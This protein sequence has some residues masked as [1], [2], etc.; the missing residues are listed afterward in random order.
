FFLLGLFG[1]WGWPVRGVLGTV[2][3][4][5]LRVNLRELYGGKDKTV[6]FKKYV[7]CDA[8]GGTGS[9]NGG[10]AVCP[11]CNGSGM[12]TTR[13]QNGWMVFQSS[14]TCPHCNG[15]GTIM[16]D[17]CHKC[18]GQGIVEKEVEITVPVRDIM[19]CNGQRFMVQGEGNACFRGKGP[20]GDLYYTYRVIIPD[21]GFSIEEGHPYNLV[22][23]LDV[24]IL[25]CLT[26]GEVDYRHI[27]GTLHKVKVERCATDGD[28][29][30]VRN[31]GLPKG[32][33][34]G[35]LVVVVH[36]VMPRRLTD[37]D[38]KLINELK[39]SQSFK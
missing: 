5:P 21:E 13:K 39:K 15:T 36:S 7:P 18:D 17:P 27:D 1:G 11:H 31:L 12:I 6:R 26:G 9:R 24:P 4:I 32:Y 16:K 14:S 28:R 19:D 34:R 2:N 8:C 37:S 3:M 33:G 35:D 22:A 30:V 38:I 25:T 23:D 10:E 29:I 20:N